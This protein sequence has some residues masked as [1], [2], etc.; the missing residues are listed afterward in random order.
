MDSM[1]QTINSGDS[2]G[3]LG[4]TTLISASNSGA[5]GSWS[6]SD[7]PSVTPLPAAFPL[8][9]GGLVTLGLLGWHRKRKADL[10]GELE[11]SAA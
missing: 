2:T 1:I 6:A 11:H 7:P 3:S 4:P 10:T 9:A 8:F 5:P